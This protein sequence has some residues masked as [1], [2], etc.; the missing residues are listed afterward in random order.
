[1]EKINS[2]FILKIK[3]DNGEYSYQIRQENIIPLI[4]KAIQEQQEQIEELKEENK[5][6]DEIISKLIER[7]EK[8]ERKEIKNELHKNKLG[9]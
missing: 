1:M 3:Q 4:S 6:K 2:N 9:E 7:V 8:L 5:K